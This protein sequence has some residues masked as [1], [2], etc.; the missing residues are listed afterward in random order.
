LAVGALLALTP[1]ATYMLASVNPNGAE[2][3][4]GLSVAVGIGLLLSAAHRASSEDF[5]RAAGP[6]ALALSYLILARPKSYLLAAGLLAVAVMI[7]P[8]GTA[9]LARESARP[10]LLRSLAPLS[11]LVAALAFDH[12]ARHEVSAGGQPAGLGALLRVVVASVDDWVAEMIGIFGWRDFMPPAG[13]AFTW[14]AAIAAVVVIA[15]A[16]GSWRARTGLTALVIGGAVVAPTFVLVTVFPG[17]AGY[18]GRY[19]MPLTVGIPILAAAVLMTSAVHPGPLGRRLATWLP[20]GTAVVSLLIW[21]GSI[22]RYSVGLPPP[23]IGQVSE[24]WTWWL[25][26]VGT[27]LVIAAFVAYVA[28]AA[29]ISRRLGRPEAWDAPQD[30]RVRA[31]ATAPGSTLAAP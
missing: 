2:I 9:A 16:A 10:L 15:L 19:Q 5:V 31:A 4:A 8:R 6:T 20:W 26:P 18:Q 28:S 25:N 11:A 7:V 29:L 24:I 23:P 27:L 14:L 21:G 22:V 12:A 17:G 30:H 3:F 1:M 13:L